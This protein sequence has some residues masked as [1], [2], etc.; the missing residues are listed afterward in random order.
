MDDGRDLRR[1]NV[2]TRVLSEVRSSFHTARVIF[3]TTSFHVSLGRFFIVHHWTLFSSSRR[4]SLYHG[5]EV[6]SFILLVLTASE[7]SGP[8]QGID[9]AKLRTVVKIKSERGARVGRYIIASTTAKYQVCAQ[10]MSSTCC[11]GS[12]DEATRRWK[13]DGCRHLPVEQTR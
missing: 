9:S 12:V 1:I 6:V 13:R 11:V 3:F 7:L 5:M 8:S 10:M 4:C 2:N